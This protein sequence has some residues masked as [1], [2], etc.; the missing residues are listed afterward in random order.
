MNVVMCSNHIEFIVLII[1]IRHLISVHYQQHIRASSINCKFCTLLLIMNLAKTKHFCICFQFGCFLCSLFQ[2]L[3]YSSF[4]THLLQILVDKDLEKH[5]H[6]KSVDCQEKAI[7][8]ASALQLVVDVHSP[9][10]WLFLTCSCHL[11]S[12]THSQKEWLMNSS[13]SN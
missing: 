2:M 8:K 3:N 4:I 9:F 11:S 12:T 13:L 1:Q 6:A 5:Q 10:S 7:R